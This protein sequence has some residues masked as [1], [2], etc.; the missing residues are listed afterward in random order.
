MNI[1]NYYVDSN[2]KFKELKTSLKNQ[3]SL[4]IYCSNQH[5]K[6]PLK[7]LSMVSNMKKQGVTVKIISL[8]QSG[9]N[10]IGPGSHNFEWFHLH[11]N[12]INQPLSISDKSFIKS[13]V[14]TGHRVILGMKIEEVSILIDRLND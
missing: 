1:I 7:C 2:G 5:E 11:Q 14:F 13:L 3:V 12:D 8:C 6:I 4:R 9:A 10:S